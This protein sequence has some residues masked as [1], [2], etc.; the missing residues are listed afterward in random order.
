METIKETLQTVMRTWEKKILQP[1]QDN[2]ELALKKLLTRKESGHI[3]FR[4]FRKGILSFNVD[5]SS[6]LYHF[7]LKKEKLLSSLQAG[8]PALKEIRFY[9]GGLE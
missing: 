8:L 3:K 6:W 5:S 1:D 4:Y 9:I 7:N 2:P